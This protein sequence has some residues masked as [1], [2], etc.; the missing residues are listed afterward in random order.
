VYLVRVQ[1]LFVREHNAVAGAI[2]KAHPELTDDQIFH[3]ARLVIAALVAKIHTLDWT[4]ELLK[5][6]VLKE[7]IYSNWH[8]LFN[9]GT[10]AFGLLGK[11]KANNHG[12]K[13][14]LTEEF[15]AIYRLHPMIPDAL[16]VQGGNN[17]Q[18]TLLTMDSLLGSTGARPSYLNLAHYYY[19]IPLSIV[20]QHPCQL[21]HQVGTA[22]GATSRALLNPCSI[23]ALAKSLR[24]GDICDLLLEP[25]T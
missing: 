16:P 23:L 13:F 14:S 19:T 10:Y 22:Q 12:V 7:A 24:G 18:P 2:S 20:V 4:V 3:K 6:R 9:L 17:M 8:G 21:L 11:S 15:T 1:D 25:P 5:T